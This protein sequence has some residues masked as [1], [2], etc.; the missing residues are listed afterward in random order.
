LGSLLKEYAISGAWFDFIRSIYWL[1]VGYASAFLGIPLLRYFWVQ[2]KNSKITSRNQQRQAR[3]KWLEQP[4]SNL[5]EKVDYARQ[6]AAETV[7][8]KKDITY[9]TEDSLD[10]GVNRLEA[11]E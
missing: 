3:Q 6:F 10:S 8:T 5:Q 2:W 1:L 7:I 9:S 4:D 11:G